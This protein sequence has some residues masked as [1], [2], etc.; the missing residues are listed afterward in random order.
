MLQAVVLTKA[1][2][3]REVTDSFNKIIDIP[4]VIFIMC[5][6][7]QLFFVFKIKIFLSLHKLMCLDVFLEPSSE[8]TVSKKKLPPKFVETFEKIVSCFVALKKVKIVGE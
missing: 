7:F 2:T 6:S 1:S 3:S 8:I 5:I 4:A